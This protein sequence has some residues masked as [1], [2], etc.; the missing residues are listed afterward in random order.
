[1]EK[2]KYQENTHFT[3][4]MP[5]KKQIQT[6]LQELKETI[7]DTITL[8]QQQLT[9]PDYTTIRQLDWNLGWHNGIYHLEIIEDPEYDPQAITLAIKI[10]QGIQ[11]ETPT[12]NKTN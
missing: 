3:N 5:T 10:L 2:P 6:E 11:E 12:T 1:M 7:Q 8:L 9:K 4:H